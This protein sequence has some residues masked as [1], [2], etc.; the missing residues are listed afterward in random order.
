MPEIN[1]IISEV[2]GRYPGALK[3]MGDLD[4]IRVHDGSALI[5]NYQTTT[6]AGSYSKAAKT[7]DAGEPGRLPMVTDYEPLSGG[8]YLI[9]YRI[10]ALGQRGPTPQGK[11]FC[12]LDVQNINGRV[13]G[14]AHLRASD[15][16]QG[17]WLSVPS[18][19]ELSND[20][21]VVFRCSPNNHTISLDRIYIFKL[22]KS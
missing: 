19:V 3:N 15:F 20:Q 11:D 2:A 18:G 1:A 16:R 13:V 21:K 5:G 7:A 9:V 8:K 22:T 10:Q 12:L 14:A 4:L 17:E 6:E